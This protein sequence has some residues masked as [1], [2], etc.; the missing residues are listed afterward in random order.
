VAVTMDRSSRTSSVKMSRLVGPRSQLSLVRNLL[1][2][3]IMILSCSSWVALVGATTDPSS[4]PSGQP[5]GQPTS[6]P[7]MRP[8]GQPSTQP[9]AQPTSSPSRIPS[10][11]PSTVPTSLP[12][13][14]PSAG[15]SSHP[16]GQPSSRPSM[17]PSGQPSTQPST[18]PTSRPSRIPSAQ[19]SSVP[20]SLPSGQPS[21]SPTSQPSSKPRWY[22]LAIPAANRLLVLPCV[23]V[24]SLPLNRRRS[25][26]GCPLLNRVLCRLLFLQASRVGRQPIDHL[27][28]Q[29]ASHRQSLRGNRRQSRPGNQVPG[30]L[31]SLLVN[32]PATRRRRQLVRQVA[33]LQVDL[34]LALQHVHLCS[35]RAD[36]QIGQAHSPLFRQLPF[37]QLNRPIHRHL[38]LPCDL[39]LNPPASLQASQ[40]VPQVHSRRHDLL[41][42]RHQFLQCVQLG[43]HPHNQQVLPV[44]ILRCSLPDSLLHSPPRV[45]VSSLL[46]VHPCTRPV[47]RHRSLLPCPADSQHVIRVLNPRRDHR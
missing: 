30:Q 47:S 35:L 36:P 40:V 42:S 45:R 10:A 6:R 14:Q 1:F 23:P 27:L 32:P 44:F 24:V 25:L 9:S 7:S 43:S 2:V 11:Q 34:P 8:S 39:L 22:R 15:P 16:S 28:S 31:V 13:G 3:F 38:S 29:V 4:E 20:T 46:A 19:P 33:N 18:Q 17:R 5:S 12:S 26:L 41:L 37:P 21:A